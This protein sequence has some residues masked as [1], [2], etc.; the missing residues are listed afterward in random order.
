MSANGKGFYQM[1]SRTVGRMLPRAFA[2]AT[3]LLAACKLSRNEFQTLD[4]WLT[5]D[6][7][8]SGERAAVE[9]MGWKAISRLQAALVRP[10][11][12]REAV[13]RAKFGESYDQ[14]LMQAR[15]PGLARKD[16]VNFRAANYV[17]N[18]QKRAAIALADVGSLGFL[19]GWRARRA[20]DQAIADSASRGYRRDVMQ[21]VHFA[22]AT[23]DGPPFSGPVSPFRVSFAD[24]VTVVAPAG[25]PFNGDERGVIEGGVFPEDD[26][27]S[28]VVGDTLVFRAVA[29]EGPHILTVKNAGK[30]NVSAHSAVLVTSVIDQNDRATS[31][32]S[33]ANIQCMV[34]SAPAIVVRPGKTFTAFLSL[35]GPTPADSG[36][37]FDYFRIRNTDANSVPYTARLNWR[38]HGDLD[39]SWRRCAPVAPV[40]NPSGVT[41]DSVEQSTEL[42]PALDC[43]IL[44]VSL[45]PGTVDTVFARLRVTRP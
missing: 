34:D 28:D 33:P 40:V 25:D 45:R 18:Y 2:V 35:W 24:V 44:V 8:D 42:V 9:A 39:L 15:V 7:C 30:G 1:T 20:L 36:D 3:L 11:A 26:I 37:R 14:A 10:A 13:M 16:Y 6:D 19:H 23:L 32:C 17:A 27:P 41:T 29:D 22:R 31:R 38:G 43:R 5:C 4:S 21:V 12:Q